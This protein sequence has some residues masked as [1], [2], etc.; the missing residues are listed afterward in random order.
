M[1][2]NTPRRGVTSDV[3]PECH[4][5]EKG[6]RDGRYCARCVINADINV[7]MK[8]ALLAFD[9]RRRLQKSPKILREGGSKG[10]CPI[11]RDN[12]RVWLDG[13]PQV[14]PMFPRVFIL[15]GRWTRHILISQITWLFVL[16]MFHRVLISCSGE[17]N[18]STTMHGKVG[19]AVTTENFVNPANL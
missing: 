16:K 14:S 11:P 13:K 8:V 12:Y 5:G 19:F 4:E 2:P 15:H 10:S 9:D 17:F 1:H 7:G 18:N 6:G 3:S